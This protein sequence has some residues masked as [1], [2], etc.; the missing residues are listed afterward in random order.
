M[1]FRPD[2]NFNAD[3]VEVRI[4]YL[5]RGRGNW[6]LGIVGDPGRKL[7]RNSNSGK[8][9]TVTFEMSGKVLQNA[10]LQLNYEGGEDTIFHMVEIEK[11]E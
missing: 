7:I 11:I 3:P 10:E 2:E 8:W 5:D 4:T 1:R 6:S 9:K